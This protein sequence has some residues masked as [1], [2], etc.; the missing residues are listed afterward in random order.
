MVG[1][2]GWNNH[3]IQTGTELGIS[4]FKS[5]SLLDQQCSQQSGFD[6]DVHFNRESQWSIHILSIL[7]VAMKTKGIAKV[8]SASIRY[9][10]RI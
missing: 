5:Q 9:I 7:F 1:R 4:E 6:G 2:V 8:S 10:R 3:S